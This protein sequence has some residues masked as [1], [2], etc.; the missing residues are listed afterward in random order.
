MAGLYKLYLAAAASGGSNVDLLTGNVKILFVDSADY[1]VNLTTDQF[2]D[3]IAA[4]ARVA[5]SGNLASKT[6]T[7]VAFDAADITVAGVSGDQFEQVIGFIDTG[8]EGT[9]RLVWQMDSGTGLPFT[10]SGGGITSQWSGS[11]IFSF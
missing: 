1:T 2:L 4:G 11:G 7:T 3:D 9:S 5:T 8:V 10:P 6:L